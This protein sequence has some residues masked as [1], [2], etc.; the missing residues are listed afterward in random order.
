MIKL[1]C[2][3]YPEVIE[4][5]KENKI[6][7]DYVKVPALGYQMQVFDENLDYYRTF[8]K[9]VNEVVPLLVHGFG[10]RSGVEIGNFDFKEKFNAKR[11]KEIIRLSGANGVSIHLAGIDTIKS[12]SENKK[13]LLSNLR[14]LKEQLADMDFISLENVD[15]NPFKNKDRFGVCIHPEFIPECF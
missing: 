9:E 14:F 4:L 10:D 2:N 8:A 6:Q 12:D 7:F 1:A 5:I 13:I 15:G 3:Y 11:T